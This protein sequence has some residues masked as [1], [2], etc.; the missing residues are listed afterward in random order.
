MPFAGV[1]P[2]R[3]RKSRS[4]AVSLACGCPG[5]PL[6]QNQRRWHLIFEQQSR[7][8]QKA[9][10]CF[11]ASDFNVSWSER[12]PPSSPP[13]HFH[14]P[15]AS[16]ENQGGTALHRCDL[17]SEARQGSSNFTVVLRTRGISW[18]L[19]VGHSQGFSQGQ[20]SFKEGVPYIYSA[21]LLHLPP[22]SFRVRN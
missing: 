16:A 11:R 6:S 4:S 15:K 13:T 21:H 12:P 1:V 7:K 5:S 19:E 14:Q 3:M 18:N 2:G 10:L 8:S 17:D 22:L 9:W 20:Y